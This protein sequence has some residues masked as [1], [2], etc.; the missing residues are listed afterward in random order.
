MKKFSTLEHLKQPE[1]DHQTE[2]ER[3]T[4]AESSHDELI[5]NLNLQKLTTD[6][7]ASSSKQQY[8]LVMLSA[9]FAY[10]ANSKVI[11]SHQ[12]PDADTESI[13]LVGTSCCRNLTRTNVFF[14]HK[15]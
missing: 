9:F 4:S 10:V 7:V 1:T 6:A 15:L 14:R 12:Q 13:G 8:S 5:P 11:T 3:L 2:D